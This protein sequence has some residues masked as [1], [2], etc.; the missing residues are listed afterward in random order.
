LGGHSLLA[1]RLTHR[2]GRALDIRVPLRLVFEHPVLAD[3]AQHLP[4]FGDRHLPIPR[5]P[6]VRNPDGTITLPAT[7]GQKRLW[8]LCSLDPRAARAYRIAGGASISGPLDRRAMVDAIGEVAR[9]HEVLRTTLREEHGE[10]VQVVHPEW[11]GG[12]RDTAPVDGTPE[13]ERELLA[14]WTEAAVDLSEGPLFRADLVRRPDDTHL[15]ML[16]LHHTVAD[17]WTL[18]LLLEEIAHLYCASV[19]GESPAESRP[20]PH[21]QYGDFA[22]WQAGSPRDEEGLAYWRDRLAGAAEPDLPT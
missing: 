22:H 2:L 1:T 13:G 21:P 9:R 20:A 11:H 12:F 3:L 19:A 7:S 6:R 8:L 10:V 16:S 15:L 4:R 5:A 14:R 18:T 17:G